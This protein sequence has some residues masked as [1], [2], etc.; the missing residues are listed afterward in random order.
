[1]TSPIFKEDAHFFTTVC[2]CGADR[3]RDKIDVTVD[4]LSITIS[5]HPVLT[6]CLLARFF[7]CNAMPID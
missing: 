1:V 4:R 3:S 6:D 5:V 7:K 2:K